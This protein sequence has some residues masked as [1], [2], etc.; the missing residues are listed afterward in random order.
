M[1]AKYVSSSTTPLIT[2]P[3]HSCIGAVIK[4]KEERSPPPASTTVMSSSSSP[5]PSSSSSRRRRRSSTSSNEEE[6][7]RRDRSRRSSGSLS[8]SSKSI[9]FRAVD[10][11][12][13]S[14]SN[15]GDERSTLTRRSI[16]DDKMDEVRNRRKIEQSSLNP[17]LSKRY[18]NW[19]H[20]ILCLIRKKNIIK[21]LKTQKFVINEVRK[22]E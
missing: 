17:N 22:L 8:K 6:G 10:D 4:R 5:P 12:N 15:R 7:S 2:K 20:M 1:G 16:A 9:L 18:A 11:A 21:N 13:K 3:I 19:S 14:V